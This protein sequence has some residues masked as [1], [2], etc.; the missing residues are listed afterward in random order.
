MRVLA[1]WR[2]AGILASGMVC[3]LVIPV[4]FGTGYHAVWDWSA[5]WMI[6]FFAALPLLAIFNAVSTVLVVLLGYRRAFELA[7]LT[8]PLTYLAALWFRP[9]WPLLVVTRFIGSNGN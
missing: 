7:S 5:L 4:V 8:V 9:Y 3:T 2:G 6:L 1:G